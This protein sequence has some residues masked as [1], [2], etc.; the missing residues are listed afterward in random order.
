MLRDL[1]QKVYQ[2]LKKGKKEDLKV[3]EENLF[4]LLLT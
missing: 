3:F 1:K 2:F 4:R